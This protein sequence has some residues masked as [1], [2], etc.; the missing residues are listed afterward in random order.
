MSFTDIHH[1]P[2]RLEAAR[3]NLWKRHAGGQER[4][5]HYHAVCPPDRERWFDEYDPPG[6][7]LL[8]S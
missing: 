5:E 2:A 4:R 8:L 6:V 1:L 7:E 3:A